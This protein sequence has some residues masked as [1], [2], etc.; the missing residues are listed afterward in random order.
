MHH[1]FVKLKCF[2]ALARLEEG[3]GVTASG[4]ARLASVELPSLYVLLP[5]WLRWSYVRRFTSRR[6]GRI[7]FYYHLTKRGR[8]WLKRAESWHPQ[9]RE[10]QAEVV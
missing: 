8:N 9:F 4:L 6:G 10:A 5:R 2:L 3:S 1:N 7:V